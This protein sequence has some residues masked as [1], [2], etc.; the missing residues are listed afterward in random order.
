MLSAA[1]PYFGLQHLRLY[2]PTH[3]SLKGEGERLG[4][5]II[6]MLKHVKFSHGLEEGVSARM[7]N[8]VVKSNTTLSTMKKCFAFTNDSYARI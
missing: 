6:L 8:V 1:G 2:L 4:A 7:V 3:L 5:C